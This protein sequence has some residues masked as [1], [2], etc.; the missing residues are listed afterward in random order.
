MTVDTRQESSHPHAQRANA[1]QL[2]TSIQ[3]QGCQPSGAYGRPGPQGGRQ[4]QPAHAKPL[5][6][7]DQ[8]IAHMKDKGITFYLCSEA[9]AAGHLRA[10]CQFFRIY[11]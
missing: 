2:E 8:Q 11:A 6:T 5:L 7:V 3:R 9:D 10:K 1:E 4:P